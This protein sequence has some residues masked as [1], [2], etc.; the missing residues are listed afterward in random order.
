MTLSKE[1]FRAVKFNFTVINSVAKIDFVM[2]YFIKKKQKM[3]I[4]QIPPLKF[5]K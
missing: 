3:A 4:F 1:I 5:W 2:F